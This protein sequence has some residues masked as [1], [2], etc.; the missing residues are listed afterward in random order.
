LNAFLEPKKDRVAAEL[1]DGE[2]I[3]INVATGT[4]YST[5]GIGGW[6]WERC[7]A[8]QSVAEIVSMGCARFEV[9]A[10]QLE[11]DL[12]AFAEILKAEDLVAERPAQP[13]ANHCEEVLLAEKQAYAAPTLLIYRDLKDLL[14]LDPPMPRL[15]QD[16]TQGV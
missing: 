11:V 16:A 5:E 3:I 1:I 4:Y 8:G 13:F 2:A 15:D 10:E 12:L 6:V 14:A 9:S 7:S